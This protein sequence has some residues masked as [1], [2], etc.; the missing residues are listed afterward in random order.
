MSYVVK[1]QFAR[2]KDLDGKEVSGFAEIYNYMDRK[3]IYRLYTEDLY[4][5]ILVDPATVEFYTGINDVLT[6]EKIFEGDVIRLK[7]TGMLVNAFAKSQ[8]ED[9]ICEICMPHDPVDS[10]RPQLYI[11]NVEGVS[12]LK[13]SED[14]D[15]KTSEFLSLDWVKVGR[16]DDDSFGLPTDEQ[17]RRLDVN[18]N[19]KGG[20]FAE[21]KSTETQIL[22]VRNS[23]H[24]LLAKIRFLG[25]HLRRAAITETLMNNCFYLFLFDLHPELRKLED[26]WTEDF[27]DFMGCPRMLLLDMCSTPQS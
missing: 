23:S 21:I 13:L 5:C 25:S 15:A 24:K 19:I 3:Y 26:K 14:F 10:V 20:M 1:R 6:G 27:I 12:D 16:V 4:D 17:K 2:A 18:P 11:Y 7:E 22:V 9:A 8:E